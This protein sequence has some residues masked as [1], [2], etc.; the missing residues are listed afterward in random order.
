MLGVVEE[1]K[2]GAKETLKDISKFSPIIV[3]EAKENILNKELESLIRQTE[4]NDWNKRVEAAEALGNVGDSQADQAA[5]ALIDLLSDSNKEVRSSAAKALGNIAYAA[6]WQTR[7]SAYWHL[8]N[9]LDDEDYE[10]RTNALY[11]LGGGNA[12]SKIRKYSNDLRDPNLDS[13]AGL[14]NSIEGLE[15]VY[16]SVKN[17][18]YLSEDYVE[19]KEFKEKLIN[20]YIKLGGYLVQQENYIGAAEQYIRALELVPEKKVELLNTRSDWKYYHR[21]EYKGIT[22]L[23]IQEKI[24]HAYISAGQYEKALN[25]ESLRKRVIVSLGNISDPNAVEPLIKMLNDKNA[26]VRR[27]AII[28]LDKIDDPRAINPL[29]NSLGDEQPDVVEEA[30]KSLIRIGDPAVELLIERLDNKSTVLYKQVIIVLGD[31]N[32]SQTAKPLIKI[33]NDKNE[34]QDIYQTAL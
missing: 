22:E 23:E 12:D 21:Y 30:R 25:D 19:V 9:L 4:S 33:I 1:V 24:A 28:A 20:A 6:D 14:E 16:E 11:S 18:N 32:T 7:D 31:S 15:Q 29:I 26:E 13:V 17:G 3:A 34:N 5:L 27:L 2:E 8:I 10:V